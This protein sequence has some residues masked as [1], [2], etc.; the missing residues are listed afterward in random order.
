MTLAAITVFSVALVSQSA[1]LGYHLSVLAYILV[2]LTRFRG[3]DE[4]GSYSRSCCAVPGNGGSGIARRLGRKRL[5]AH[6]SPVQLFLTTRAPWRRVI[7]A[8]GHRL[9]YP[10][11]I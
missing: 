4:K 7:T 6:H 11:L 10:F 5:R 2:C 9:L 3:R 8:F 1:I